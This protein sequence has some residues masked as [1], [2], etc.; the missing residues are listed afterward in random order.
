MHLICVAVTTKVQR[1]GEN[2]VA[3][4]RHPNILL[5]YYRKKL[6]ETEKDCLLIWWYTSNSTPALA[7]CHKR[8]T[9][10]LAYFL[11]RKHFRIPIIIPHLQYLLIPPF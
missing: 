1:M 6:R 8:T 11:A 5:V 10:F 4:R 9:I 3:V 2:D 7:F